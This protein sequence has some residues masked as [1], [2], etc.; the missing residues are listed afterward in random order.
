[1]SRYAQLSDLK[2]YLSPNGTLSSSQDGLLQ[3]S[4]DRA[5]SAINDYTRRNFVGTAG[6]VYVNRYEQDHVRSQALYLQQDLFSLV[7]LQNGDTTTIPVGSVWLEPRNA[8]P[9]Y[10]ML[11]LKS[12][13][14]FVWNTDSDIVISGT[15]GYGTVPPDSV[16]QAT[17]RYATFLFRQKDV[18]PGDQAGF[19]EAGEQ[20]IPKGMPDD[21]RYLLAPFRSRSGGVV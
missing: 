21:V 13:Y 15:F 10:R 12:Q 3:S 6:T 4:L 7:A 8:G 5:E 11:R 1:M 9:P 17:V 19:P 14:V 2:Y 16:V 18:A 20:T